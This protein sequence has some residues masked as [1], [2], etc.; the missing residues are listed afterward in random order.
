MSFWLPANGPL[1][2]PPQKPVAR[3]LSTDDYVTRTNIY[4]HA[5]SDRLLTVG[6]PFYPVSNN[7]EV[8]IPKVSGNQFRVWRIQLPNPN[9]FALIDPTVYNPDNERLVWALR[10]MEIDRGGPLGI[11]CTGHPLFN[12]YGDTENPYVYPPAE[13]AEN[14]VSAAMDPKQMQLFIVGCSPA[15]GEHWDS[16]D[17]C[18]AKPLNRGDCPLLE[19]KHTTIEDGDMADIGFGAMNYKT[20]AADRASVPLDIVNSICKWPDFLKMAK[21]IYGNQVFFCGRR[22]QMYGRHFSSRAGT[23][24]EKIPFPNERDYFLSPANQD[25]EGNAVA[26][27]TLASQVY[28]TVP[29]G[30]LVSTDGQIFGRPYWLQRSQGMNN[31]ICWND[32][33]F[34]TV[35]DNTHNTNL[36]ISVYNKETAIDDNYTYNAADFKQYVRHFEE[37][38]LEFVF[39]LCKVKLDADVLSHLHVMDPTILERWQL[40]FVPP[41]PTG[42]ED[43]YR[44]INSMAVK[45]PPSNSETQ[46]E[47]PYKN[48]SFWNLDFSERFT[49]DLT[50]TSLGRRFLYQMG[51][52]SGTNISSGRKRVYT[53][54]AAT[55]RKTVK[56]RKVRS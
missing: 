9:K 11:G 49:S 32:Q 28:F 25:S 35:L 13:N 46:N 30:S 52:L 38:E 7:D 51:L 27:H 50:Q 36:T 21:D 56:R 2:L 3:V 39:Q 41:P 19:L 48:L 22:E 16:A 31:G 20:L 8:E 43:A 29:S 42:L 33:L 18:S 47:D 10:G 53:D 23:V 34:L 45:C 14:R 17:A 26:Q 1:Y 12:K 15:T 24:G 6:N 44:Y 4:F 37:Y 55:P 40:G 5:S 54:T